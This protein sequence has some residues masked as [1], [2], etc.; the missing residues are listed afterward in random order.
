LASLVFNDPRYLVEFDQVD[1]YGE[2]RLLAI[3]RLP[4]GAV[5]VVG[6][7]ERGQ[8]ENGEEIR[9]IISARKAD[10]SELER[11]FQQAAD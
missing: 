9:H 6:H 4:N 5:L 11:Y 7:I 10:H 3:G 1:E 2:E 8:D